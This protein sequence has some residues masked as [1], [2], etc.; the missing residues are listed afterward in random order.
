M[1][2]VKNIFLTGYKGFL[3]I[4]LQKTNIRKLNVT[5]GKIYPADDGIMIKENMD[6]EDF[7]CICH[8]GASSKR[9][10]KYE[11][12][13]SKNII[14][15]ENLFYN[16]SK[17][18]NLKIIYASANSI[19]SSSSNELIDFKAKPIPRE[20]YS[21]SKLLGEELLFNYI[22]RKNFTIIRLPAI[23]GK[24][25]NK[26]GLIDRLI[27]LFIKNEKINITNDSLLITKAAIV[28][29]VVNFIVK[30][31]I[32]INKFS[33]KDFILGSK[34]PMS[35]NDIVLYIKNRLNSDSEIIINQKEIELELC[36]GYISSREIWF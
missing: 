13:I 31:I 26:E 28:D 10:N 17:Y 23:Y 2:S 1:K 32:N 4:L 21:V 19:V 33:G 9:S 14:H 27:N 15:T 16:A 22:K 6:L 18:S 8:L 24:D 35:L 5:F 25:S 29:D 7:D 30:S 12:I 20:L 3:E 36:I 11:D 34:K